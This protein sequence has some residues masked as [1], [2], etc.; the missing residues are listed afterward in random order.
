MRHAMSSSPRPI[1]LFGVA[2]HVAGGL[3]LGR[4]A[5]KPGAPGLVGGF[6]PHPPAQG[7]MRCLG[8]ER[9]G[10]RVKGGARKA[11][12]VCAG[13]AR[14]RRGDFAVPP[15]SQRPTEI[16]YRF[17]VPREKYLGVLPC[18]HLLGSIC[19]LLPISDGRFVSDSRGFEV[20][21]MLAKS[22][23]RCG[24][25]EDDFDPARPCDQRAAQCDVE[26]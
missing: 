11:G 2:L 23:R 25:W 6:G 26:L 16:I 21:L 8:S 5:Q 20:Q 17:R 12:L 7:A 18:A 24:L 1:R 10:R 14:K 4:S 15:T 3:V 19:T 22:L 13:V 9:S